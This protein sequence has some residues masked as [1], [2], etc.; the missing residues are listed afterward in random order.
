MWQRPRTKHTIH[1]LA[2]LID[3]QCCPLCPVKPDFYQSVHSLSSR[4][5]EHFH[6]H[7][8]IYKRLHFSPGLLLFEWTYAVAEPHFKAMGG[9]KVAFFRNHNIKHGK[10]N[11]M[12]PCCLQSDISHLYTLLPCDDPARPFL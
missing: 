1:H 10:Q 11:V 6:L 5:H 4:F 7:G 9:R 12:L 8:Y 3:I 2:E